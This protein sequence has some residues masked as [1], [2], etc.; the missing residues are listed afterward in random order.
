MRKQC[1]VRI[2]EFDPSR[3]AWVGGDSAEHIPKFLSGELKKKSST[4]RPRAGAKRVAA[5]R[6][7]AA[8][9]KS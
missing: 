5:K 2:T 6:K 7:M 8:G 9:Q 1:A 3:V 4:S